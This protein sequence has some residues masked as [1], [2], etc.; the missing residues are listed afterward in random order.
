MVI[1]LISIFLSCCE[2]AHDNK[3]FSSENSKS[4]PVKSNP[5]VVVLVLVASE[6]LCLAKYFYYL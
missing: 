1:P 2:K 3:E 4:W 5:V 6:P